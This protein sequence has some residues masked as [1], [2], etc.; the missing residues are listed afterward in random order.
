MDSSEIKHALIS[1]LETIEDKDTLQ[2]VLLAVHN[3]LDS[4]D[5]DAIKNASR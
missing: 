3:I 5:I 2:K 1:M 4:A